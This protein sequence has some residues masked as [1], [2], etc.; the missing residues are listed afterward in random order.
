MTWPPDIQNLL[1]NGIKKKTIL[2]FQVKL[3]TP[4][5]IKFGGDV[6]RVT[7]GMQLF[8]PEVL[9]I[10]DVDSAH[11]NLPEVKYDCWQN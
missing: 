1:R 2:Y 5:T 11:H 8:L 7:A 4:Q 3:P 6:R 9:E 10:V